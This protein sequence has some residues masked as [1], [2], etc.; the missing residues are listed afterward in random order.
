[1]ITCPLLESTVFFALFVTLFH[2]LHAPVHFVSLSFTRSQRRRRVSC[3]RLTHTGSGQVINETSSITD[4]DGHEMHVMEGD[5]A[6]LNDVPGDRE[7]TMSRENEIKQKQFAVGVSLFSSS[8][9]LLLFTIIIIIIIM[10][11]RGNFFFRRLF[12]LFFILFFLL[13]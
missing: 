2:T 1:M 8:V 10:I 3:C 5:V 13:L 4:V 6:V 11:V 9:S 7:D 12:L